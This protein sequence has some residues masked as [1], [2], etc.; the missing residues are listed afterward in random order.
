MK[1][2]FFALLLGVAVPALTFG[3][4]AGNGDVNGDGEINISDAIYLINWQFSDGP[5]PVSL[6]CPTL[7]PTEDELEPSR[8]QNAIFSSIFFPA[9]CDFVT[10]GSNDFF[11]LEPG[12]RLMLEGE[13]EDD[14]EDGELVQI[15]VEITVLD[16]LET[17]DG[18]VTRVVEEREWEDGELIEVSRNFFAICAQ[19]GDV[20]YF[21][22][23]VDD[24][25]DGEIVG[26]GG[27]WRA[28]VDGAQAGVLVPGSPLVGA[29]HFQEIAPDLAL[30]RVEIINFLDSMEVPAGEFETVMFVYETSALSPDDE[31]TKHYALGVGLI[32]DDEIELTEFGFIDG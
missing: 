27:A 17:V 24:Y 26:H 2:F 28:G 19:T 22:E 23:D 32:Q 21:G 11:I 1:N 31:S 3:G 25:E 13:E 29:R 20:Y 9:D 12:Y 5:E 14:E 16:E 7:A 30:D 10:E 4:P 8:H 18:V 15:R 6:D